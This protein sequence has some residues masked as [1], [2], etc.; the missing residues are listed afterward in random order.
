VT[1]AYHLGRDKSNTVLL[2]ASGFLFDIDGVLVDSTA[3]VERHWRRFA[4]QYG[5]DPGALLANVHG[6]RAVDVIGE[7]AARLR[8]PMDQVIREWEQHDTN[9]QAGVT[10]LPGA[11]RTLEQL[12]PHCWAAVTSG[13][14]AVA[15]SRLRAADLPVPRLLVTAD[16]V[17]AGKPDPA[18]YL[19]GAEMLGLRP[20]ECLAVED[21]PQGLLS[22][23]RAGCRTLALLTTHTR[24]QLP[25]AS[26]MARDL[27]AVRLELVSED[28]IGR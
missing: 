18:P 17:P 24:E 9:D 27:T 6:R 22:A 28:G 10:A 21:A 7:L 5:L 14:A 3:I 8:S 19:A 25:D 23:I 4:E 16:D 12:P 15:R 2:T 1:D 26:V 11:A 13:S 20:A